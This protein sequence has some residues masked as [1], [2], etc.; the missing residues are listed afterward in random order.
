VSS[1]R[2]TIVIN[3]KI[4]NAASGLPIHQ[5]IVI[6]PGSTPQK[7]KHVDGIIHKKPVTHSI[8][9]S[10]ALPKAKPHVARSATVSSSKV[11]GAPE[12]SKTL[13]R[14]MLKKPEV[15]AGSKTVSLAGPTKQPDSV[16][17]R[18]KRNSAREER[19]AHTPR[20]AKVHK[21]KS[22]TG[23]SIVTR[24]EEMAVQPAPGSQPTKSEDKTEDLSTA[25]P[26]SLRKSAPAQKRN[27]FETMLRNAPAPAP[28]NIGGRKHKR[29]SAHRGRSVMAAIG[30][31]LILGGF[32]TYYSLPSMRMQIAS[33]KSGFIASVPRYKPSGFGLNTAIQYQPGRVT[34]R[35]TS[36]T[37]AGNNFTI[38]QEK[39]A[40]DS[41]SMVNSYLGTTKDK[42]VEQSS[43]GRTVYIYN[44]SNATWVDGGIWYNIQANA[45]L[46]TDQLLRIAASM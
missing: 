26:M 14:Q 38:T 20:H 25:P 46:S 5:P 17:M 33:R 39:T 34:M 31:F 36:A 45:Q 28:A 11:H 32:F 6:K 4:Y 30:V 23:D 41:A 27:S 1:Q 42:A 29:K 19:A 37:D 40:L 22:H 16:I 8:A 18:A 21:F 2:D 9:K 35:Y 3:G 24:V 7:A 15:E 10:E 43:N 44:G 13:M 12:R